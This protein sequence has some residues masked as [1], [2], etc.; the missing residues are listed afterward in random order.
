MV[1]I[2]GVRCYIYVHADSRSQAFDRAMMRTNARKPQSYVEVFTA[3]ELHEPVDVHIQPVEVS[4][5]PI[6]DLQGIS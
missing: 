3:Q 6:E 2:D 4:I 5:T 1:T